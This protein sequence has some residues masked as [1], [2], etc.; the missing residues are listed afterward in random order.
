MI[1]SGV[2]FKSPDAARLRAWYARWLGIPD[3]GYGTDFP[4][5]SI[6]PGGYTVWSPFAADTRYF[7]PSPR[8]FMINLMVD[9]LDGALAQVREGGAEVVGDI[10]P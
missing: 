2:F 9:D 8:E 1:V 4:R 10:E 3:K 6:P 7:D 5:S